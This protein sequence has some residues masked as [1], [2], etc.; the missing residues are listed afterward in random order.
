MLSNDNNGPTGNFVINAG[1]NT[2]DRQ[3][4]LGFYSAANGHGDLGTQVMTL[5]DV[6]YVGIG[7]PN[8]SEKLSVEGNIKVNGNIT[9]DGEMCIGSGC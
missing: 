4:K 2:L 6:G 3:N 9:S 1:G 8:P 5:T 7:T